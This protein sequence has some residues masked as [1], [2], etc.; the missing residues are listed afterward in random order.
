MKKIEKF[1]LLPFTILFYSLILLFTRNKP[2]PSLNG[3]SKEEI[4]S[5][6]AAKNKLQVQ[7]ESVKFAMQLAINRLEYLKNLDLKNNKDK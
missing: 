2:V 4:E 6:I 5:W 3:M 1:L 7:D